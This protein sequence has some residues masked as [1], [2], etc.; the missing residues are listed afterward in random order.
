[1]PWFPDFANAAA[2]AR[3]EQVRSGMVDPVSQYLAALQEGSSRELE[4][5]WPGHLVVHDPRA[6]A[7]TGHRA[8]R[9]FVRTN[10]Q[11]LEGR[12]ATVARRNATT[13]NGCSVVEL[14]VD[15]TLSDGD[16]TTW[17]VAVVAESRDPSA[18]EFRTYCTQLPVDGRRHLRGPLL[19]P[20][21]S[22][23]D[24]VVGN[25]LTALADGDVDAIV[26]TFAPHGY[27]QESIAPRCVHSGAAELRTYYSS[28]VSLGRGAR[29]VPCRLTD[30]LTCCAVE[31]TCTSWGGS[32]VPPQAGLAVYE[33]G[34]GGL[35][36]AVRCY[37][38]IVQPTGT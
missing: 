11:W 24:D 30:D 9:E 7:V 37:D 38:D 32:E 22:R 29:L 1:V 15:L 28:Q 26:G 2:L 12:G 36:A 27:L 8:L 18:V 31:Y 34:A 35:I 16:R 25:H 23:A 20:D 17:P 6:G 4:I 21:G 13:Q 10:R 3:R 19:E 33:R 5:A 14:L